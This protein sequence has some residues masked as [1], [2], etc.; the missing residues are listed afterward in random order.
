MSA[1]AS[2]KHFYPSQIFA[3]TFGAPLER[4]PTPVKIKVWCLN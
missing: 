1:L 2:E 3:G 4:A